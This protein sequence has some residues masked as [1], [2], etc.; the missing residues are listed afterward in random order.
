MYTDSRY[1]I[2]HT[3]RFPT[4]L[5]MTGATGIVGAASRTNMFRLPFKAKLVKFGIIPVEG[6]MGVATTIPAFA[7]KLEAPDGT[8]ATELATFVPGQTGQID[9]FEA[10]GVAPET[11]TNI[12]AGRVVM[13]C[14]TTAGASAGSVIFFM[15]YQQVY[16][17]GGDIFP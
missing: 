4:L 15:D 12:P 2:V 11:A 17:S 9:Q 1:D 5:D 13:P 3:H 10:T 8:A 6:T 7:L 16:I 14:T